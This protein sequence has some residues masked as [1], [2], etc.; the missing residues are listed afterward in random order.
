MKTPELI[1]LCTNKLRI[2][3]VGGG[4]SKQEI[5]DLII[6]SG[7]ID[8]ISAP[9]PMSV[10]NISTLRGM[11]V[12]KLKRLMTEAGVFFDARDVIEKEDMVQIF[13]N[14]G[15][16]VFEEEEKEEEDDTKGSYFGYS[17]NYGTEEEKEQIGTRQG[18]EVKRARIDEEG[19][20]ISTRSMSNDNLKNDILKS[21]IN[22]KQDE[23][24]SANENNNNRDDDTNNSNDVMV[25]EVSATSLDEIGHSINDDAISLVEG[26]SNIEVTLLDSNS[27]SAEREPEVVAATTTRDSTPRRTTAY[28]HNE[29][30]DISSRS[31]SELKQ[32]A[33][34]LGIDVSNCLEKREMI[35]QIV[36]TL[37]RRGVGTRYGGGVVG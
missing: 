5:I 22:D 36:E 26:S 20:C 10:K 24:K 28:S 17:T 13:M 15:R 16:I 8:V 12:G 2:P 35:R 21:D 6:S 4:Y 31:I 18:E 37:S 32:L 7:K 9:P 25:E 1:D 14:S 3:I 19:S 30:A 23:E 29:S 27:E 34:S 33:R 11:G